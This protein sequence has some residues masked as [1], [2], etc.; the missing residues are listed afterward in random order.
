[1][2]ERKWGD[3]I[4]DIATGRNNLGSEMP[5]AV[6]RLFEFTMKEALIEEFGEK[7]AIRLFRVAGY[8]A[9]VKFTEEMLNLKA[10]FNTFIAEL[11]KVLKDL[12]IG[13]F[14]VEQVDLKQKKLIVS[15]GEDLDCSGL[16]VTGKTV[17]NYDEGFLEGIMKAYTHEDYTVRETD[18]WGTG[19]RV[20]RFTIQKDE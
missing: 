16:P 9:G 6:Y 3:F 7:E 15:I 12:K 18:C 2:E 20:C 4:G 8:K 13:I 14:R 5:V 11:Q 19:S 17:C 1:M 10:N